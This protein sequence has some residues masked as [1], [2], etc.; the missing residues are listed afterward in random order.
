MTLTGIPLS[1]L[2]VQLEKLV[3]KSL[4]LWNIPQDVS[5]ELINVSENFT[6]RIENPSG[7]K[8]ILRVHRENYHS[9]RSI[10]CELTW[11]DALSKS[12]LI[13]TPSYFFGKDGSAIQECSIDN[14]IGS[15]YLVLFHFVSGSA[16]EENKNLDTLYEKLGRLA[17]TCHNHVLSWEKP[18][19]FERL[20]WDIDTIFGSNALWGNWRLAPE[21]TK[22]V[23][24]KLE[25]VELKIRGRLLDYGKSEKR[26]NLI[27]ADMRLANLLIDQE[28]TRLIDFDD[29]GFGW[30]M[31]DFAS[32]ISFIEDSPMVSFF[33]SSWIKGYKSVRELSVEDEKKL[34]H[35]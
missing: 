10:E 14:I 11:I 34:I 8:A 35:L 12:G 22:E 7:F 30:F 9:R 19:N 15:R 27:H 28:S 31:Y 21:V 16:P 1:T 26:F 25:R 32:A 4:K 18:D 5:A 3:N 29:C 20:T 33:K 23:Q 24:D 17:G 13:E 6:Y 2:L